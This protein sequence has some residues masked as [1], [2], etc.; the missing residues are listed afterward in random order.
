MGR[1]F[2]SLIFICSILM[3]AFMGSAQNQKMDS[4]R[5]Y[6]QIQAESKNHRYFRYE[7]GA[8][9]SD[10]YETCI[11]NYGYLWVKTHKYY[12]FNGIT[13][14]DMLSLVSASERDSIINPTDSGFQTT[15][16][17]IMIASRQSL[18]QWNGYAFKKYLFPKYDRIV[19]YKVSGN[20]VLC[21]GVHGFA[22]LD[23]GKW[24]YTKIKMPNLYDEF[25]YIPNFFSDIISSTSS[26]TIR[27]IG[28]DTNNK[29]HYLSYELPIL[30]Q[31][32]SLFRISVKAT[33]RDSDL[34]LSC[35]SKDGINQNGIMSSTEFNRLIEQG[36]TPMP[37]LSNAPVGLILYVRDSNSLFKFDEENKN[38]VKQILNEKST[39]VTCDADYVYHTRGDSLFIT[40]LQ[41]LGTSAQIDYYIPAKDYKPDEYSYL[42]LDEDKDENLVPHRT[43]SGDKLKVYKLYKNVAYLNPVA[44][45]SISTDGYI[46][47]HNN[48]IY[49]STEAD[50]PGIHTITLHNLY[51][52]GLKRTIKVTDPANKLK[53]LSFNKAGNCLLVAGKE[54]LHLINL[55]QPCI[56]VNTIP[57]DAY[58]RIWK[59]AWDTGLFLDR[60]SDL[61][62]VAQVGD[63][64][65]TL[66]KVSKAREEYFQIENRTAISSGDNRQVHYL[67]SQRPEVISTTSISKN[68][69]MI[70]T[71]ISLLGDTVLDMDNDFSY[72]VTVK[73]ES[74]TG[75][76][77]A[78]RLLLED[79]YKKHKLH[80]VL[81]PHTAPS[82]ISENMILMPYHR[83]IANKR[84][85]GYY[86]EYAVIKSDR[87]LYLPNDIEI[88]HGSGSTLHFPSI[89]Y[90]M[91]NDVAI[92]QPTWMS[93]LVCEDKEY[94]SVY[95]L[96]VESPDGKQ[97][98]R[99]SRYR[100]GKLELDDSDLVLPITN[101]QFPEYRFHYIGNKFG[102]ELNGILHYPERNT[103]RSVSLEQYSRFGG[104][105]SVAARRNELWLAF[106]SA[107]VRLS[108]PSNQ[109]FLFTQKD[110]IP[111][112]IDDLYINAGNIYI[113]SDKTVYRFAPEADGATL[114]VPRLIANGK[115]YNAASLVTLKHNRNNVIFSVDILNTIFPEKMKLA[116]RL[117]G[118]E[119]EWK[120]R[121][122]TPQ[123]EYPRLP[124]GRYEFQINA[125]SPIGRRAKTLSVF[126]II[127]PPIYGTWWA[128][129]LYAILLFVLGRY[130][131]R[132]RI[133]QLEAR[134]AS[135]E[136]TI[137][138]RTHELQ[139]RQQH[140]KQ[141]IDYASLIQQSTLPQE[142]DMLD[143]FAEHFVI[144]KPRDTVGGDF[145]W[146]HKTATGIVYF[147]VIDCTGHG[148]PGALMSMTV[149]SLLNHIIKDDGLN[150]PAE[151]LQSLHRE[152][153]IALHQD[154]E[155]TQQDGVEI[156][157]LKISPE[158]LVFCGAGLHLLYHSNATEG[159]IQIR[160]DKRGLGGLRWRSEL[161]LNE[162]TIP[163][164]PGMTV[165]LYTDGIVDQPLPQRDRLV[166]FGQ[167]KLIELLSATVKTDMDIQEQAI[168]E[169]IKLLLEYHEQR[170]DITVV[171]LK[172][173]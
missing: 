65:K 28:L 142:A 168:N 76:A 136:K 94:S 134:N 166:R 82:L 169:K 44:T 73:G 125:T 88:K 32:G 52:E 71:G 24:V 97:Q 146:M 111:E 95:I 159:I 55:N 99:F 133:R 113:L 11:D 157:L 43:G 20:K 92:F 100:N 15:D 114:L 137:A 2:K 118:Y 23:S 29:L 149:Y 57:A 153:S 70:I 145:Y 69:S 158:S 87:D 7:D 35:Y 165:Y 132:L 129:L 167:A 22:V 151:I 37:N 102:I 150:E 61:S 59:T 112:R 139:E 96:H 54:Q 26:I 152:I 36:K 147:A 30:V 89:L 63:T 51:Y 5:L 42:I 138:V 128:Y 60:D 162:H 64:F 86:Y 33:K 163:H 126:F 25:G 1:G 67:S 122:Y 12:L 173:R 131:Y 27:C 105:R 3:L 21:I 160:G 106:D 62:F 109:S 45:A 101:N 46:F 80:N 141:S 48:L 115:S 103:W 108:I 143:A 40:S 144:W 98:M 56:T 31:F 68:R 104:L 170:D 38:F 120:Q 156:S 171:G 50:K 4:L 49:S 127:K 77:T 140:I 72:T 41:D 79:R 119:K 8:P 121:D 117:L 107:V 110:G 135:L 90:D 155:H 9:K 148:V 34:E 116:Y 85:E 17:R 84:D 124:P 172:L 19:L 91:K 39:I 6:Q 81:K 154:K 164:K 16:K 13:F 66:K 74:R 75:E 130:L 78:L 47:E 123:I 53:L 161:E 14:K 93:A 83:F 18:Y 58:T 10:S